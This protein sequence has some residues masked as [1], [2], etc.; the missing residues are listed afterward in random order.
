MNFHPTKCPHCITG[1]MKQ[2]K[3]P[4]SLYVCE[5]CGNFIYAYEGS[6]KK[7]K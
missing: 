2:Q 1:K 7:K 6:K 4:K 5:K 3:D